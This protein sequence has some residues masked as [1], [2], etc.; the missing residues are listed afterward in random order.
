LAALDWTEMSIDGSPHERAFLAELSGNQHL[1]AWQ[2]ARDLLERTGRWPILCCDDFR[3]R[4]YFSRRAYQ[5]G[6]AMDDVSPAAIASAAES[7]EVWEFL[8][9]LDPYPTSA[10]EC[11]QLWKLEWSTLGL[12][13]EYLDTLW[14]DYGGDRLRCEHMLAERER[15]LGVTDPQRGRQTCYSPDQPVLVLLP[16]N[17]G[18]HALAYMHFYGMRRGR[19]EGYVR[20]LQHWSERYGAELYAHYGTMLEFKVSRPP[21]DLETALELA[22]EHELVAPCTLILPG[23]ALRHYA[24]GLIDHPMWF[25]HERP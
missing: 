18:P 6:P 5:N 13:T 7:M 9:R 15:A 25:L 1:E 23:I 20:L 12:A 3:P 21:T 24:E 8:D 14:E 2:C 4:N 16:T 19:P 10:A 17:L 11:L 22:R